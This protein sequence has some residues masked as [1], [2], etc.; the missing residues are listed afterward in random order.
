[1][2]NLSIAILRLAGEDVAGSKIEAKWFG[3]TSPPMGA[4][5]LTDTDSAALTLQNFSGLFI[6][7][8]SISTLML[9]ISIL[10]LVRAKCTGLRRANMESV[11]YSDAEHDSHPLQNGMGDNPSPD[12]QPLREA[13][14]GDSQGVHGSGQNAGDLEPGPVQQNC[15]HTGSVPAKHIQIETI[16]L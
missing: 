8:G 15:M 13:R 6:I 9:L 7:T 11:S 5:T 3:T 10:R 16:I 2:H 14:N 1:M 12:H 4:G